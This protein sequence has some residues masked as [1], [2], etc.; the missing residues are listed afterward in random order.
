MARSY[1]K[2]PVYTDR[3]NGA[4][5]WKRI[6]NK[7]VRKS[8]D[9]FQKGKKYKKFY[10]SWEIHDFS[11][12]WSKESALEYYNK[13]GF[14]QNGKWITSYQDEYKTEKDFLNKFWGK[15]HKRK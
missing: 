8:K 4:K 10:N 7:K 13:S 2:N 9:Y 15:H 6:G 1:K 11:Y 5:Y 14:F 3:P 12:R